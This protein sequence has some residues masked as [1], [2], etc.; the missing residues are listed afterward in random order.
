MEQYW[1]IR[2][3]ENHVEEQK[4]LSGQWLARAKVNTQIY[5]HLTH[6][7][8]NATA[9]L[10]AEGPAWLE[11]F[12]HLA[13]TPMLPNPTPVLAEEE[14]IQVVP[15]PVQAPTPEEAAPTTSA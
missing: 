14:P 4:K 13:N 12:T 11:V 3:E 9:L 2:E 1:Q 10:T 5:E 6:E 15:T 7:S 8:R